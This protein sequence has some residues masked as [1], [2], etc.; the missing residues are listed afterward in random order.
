MNVNVNGVFWCSRA[1]GKHMI[2]ARRGSIVNLGSMSGTIC[3][4]PQPQ[5]PYNV[6]K[7]AVHHMTRSIAAEWAPHGVRV[8]AVAP[9]YIETP[10]V[11]A[12]PGKRAAHR[13]VAAR[14]ADGPHGPGR[15]SRQRRAVPC[16]RRVEPDDGSHRARRWRVHLLVGES[17]GNPLDCVR[18]VQ[19]SRKPRV[20]RLERVQLE[21]VGFSAR[22]KS[23]NKWT[24]AFP[25]ALPVPDAGLRAAIPKAAT[26]TGPRECT[27]RCCRRRQWGR[28]IVAW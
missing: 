26:M 7:A 14:H 27:S 28:P 16:L 17:A 13:S 12:N 21:R 25:E 20:D 6:S 5:T 22:K 24:T 23:S 15:R 18:P 10:M 11:L 19:S 3:N 2:A 8:N 9:T 4:R 1:F